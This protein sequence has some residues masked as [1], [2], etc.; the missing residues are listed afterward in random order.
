MSVGSA[1]VIV[2]IR[3]VIKKGKDKMGW[4]INEKHEV[5]LS[6]KTTEKLLSFLESNEKELK[7]VEMSICDYR[8]LVSKTED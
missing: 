5:T 3:D 2:A 4:E 1:D 6:F 8:V 7:N